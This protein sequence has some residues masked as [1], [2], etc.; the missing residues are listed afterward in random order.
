MAPKFVTSNDLEKR[1]FVSTIQGSAVKLAYERTWDWWK[2]YKV[3]T[4][5]NRLSYNSI[6]KGFDILASNGIVHVI[7]IF[8]APPEPLG[9]IVEV[10]SSLPDFSTHVEIVVYADLTEAMSWL[11]IKFL[12]ALSWSPSIQMCACPL[13]G[14]VL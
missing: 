2:G 10:A 7:D 6:V 3:V 12:L 9:N 4:T 11:R 8:L 13:Q 1:G 14:C 5:L